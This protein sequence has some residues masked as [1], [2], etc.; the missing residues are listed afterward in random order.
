[1]GIDGETPK[2]MI[3]CHFSCGNIHEPNI[4]DCI[5]NYNANILWLWKQ[6]SGGGGGDGNRC[7]RCALIQI[8]RKPT[9]YCRTKVS[10]QSDERRRKISTISI[11][12]V[13]FYLICKIHE[14][15]ADFEPVFLNHPFPHPSSS[16]SQC[17]LLNAHQKS[18]ND[19]P[20]SFFLKLGEWFIL[21]RTLYK[22]DLSN[23]KYMRTIIMQLG[24]G[25]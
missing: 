20:N 23:I 12:L 9:I 10:R 18:L 13:F 19:Q 15:F 11:T 22:I 1:M 3:C 17:H 6:R 21:T 5:H 25:I 7:K 8:L 2:Q 24:R 14:C 4:R 16:D